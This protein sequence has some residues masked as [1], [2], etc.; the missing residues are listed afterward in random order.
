MTH[1]RLRRDV[2]FLAQRLPH[3]GANT[4]NERVAAEYLHERFKEHARDATIDDFYSID[5]YAYLFALYYFDFLFAA[6][7]AVW[8]PWIG[9]GYGLAIFLM[10][11]AEITGYAVMGRLLPQYETQ[12]VSAR[13][14]CTAPRQTIVIAA[15]YDSPRAS[16]LTEPERAPQLRAAHLVIVLCMVLV[17]GA[18]AAAALG[19]DDGLAGQI[20][21]WVSWAAVTLLLAAGFVLYMADAN[22]EYTRGANNNASGTAVLLGLAERLQQRPLRATDVI[23]L[24]TGSKETWL[25]GMQH[26][27]REMD[28]DKHR[29]AFITVSSVG[30]GELRYTRGEGLLHVY[31]SAKSLVKVARQLAPEYGAREYLYQGIPTDALVPLTRGYYT[32][33]IMATAEDGLPK[34]WNRLTDTV[35]EI[36]FDALARAED[37]VDA[38]LRSLDQK[39]FR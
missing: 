34:H 35:P 23:L 36:D 20:R 37:Y 13:F 25:H 5:S 16:F 1:P 10:Y 21:N 6:L 7:F 3:R 31:R 24:A 11:M 17:I 26:F 32:L 9:F 2:E 33:G 12:N 22:G 28:L 38:I 14:L 18:C 15:N 39:P 4:Q 27:I 30:A 8:W 19:F 29:T